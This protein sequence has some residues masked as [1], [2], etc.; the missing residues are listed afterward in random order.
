[1]DI[2]YEAYVVRKG[3][4]A[5]YTT[6]WIAAKNAAASN[7]I[8]DTRYTYIYANKGGSQPTVP[9][10]A[11]Q[12]VTLTPPAVTSLTDIDLGT[13]GV[14]G[15]SSYSNG[16]WTV[17]GAGSG[18]SGGHVNAHFAY[19]PT[20]GNCIMVA[21]ITSQTATGTYCDAGILLRDSLSSSNS[22]CAA[23]LTQP[24][25][26]G[27]G[28]FQFFEG[29]SSGGSWNQNHFAVN[30]VPIPQWL[31][32]VRDG[33]LVSCFHS[34]DG[35]N[36]TPNGEIHIASNS[37]Y[38]GLFVSSQNTTGLSTATFTNVSIDSSAGSIGSGLYTIANRNS[39]FN[40]DV[41]AATGTNGTRIDQYPANGCFNQLW[42]ISVLGGGNYRIVGQGSEKC[43]D[44]T[45]LSQ[46]DGANLEIWTP[47]NG[48]NQQFT[49]I[50]T[51]SGYEEISP[52]CSGKAVE[53]T[54]GSLSSGANVDQSTY[55][56]DNSQQWIFVSP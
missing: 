49:L 31:K 32:V 2:A 26:T 42:Y 55:T 19:V 21:K 4:S 11:L 37:M 20:K 18:L 12:D 28:Q 53:V 15:S 16:T 27:S 36:W 9:P 52:V 6:Q 44:L 7:G 33:A 45:A 38:I 50:D 40:M 13:T 46:A 8:G 41:V 39:G 51:D 10:A 3:M 14:S 17:S 5:P 30:G 23:E 47:N 1:M 54:G 34:P 29:F 35:V 22:N 25:T 56:G 48:T 43:L 24:V